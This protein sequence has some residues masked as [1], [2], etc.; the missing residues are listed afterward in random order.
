MF[1]SPG[2]LL[3]V[4]WSLSVTLVSLCLFSCPWCVLNSLCCVLVHYFSFQFYWKTLFSTLASLELKLISLHWLHFPWAFLFHL[5]I[6]AWYLPIL[7]S[8]FL[9]LYKTYSS[10]LFPG[11]TRA[12]CAVVYRSL[13]SDLV[14]VGSVSWFGLSCLILLS[15]P[16]FLHVSQLHGPG[17]R[18]GRL[19]SLPAP[20]WYW[21]VYQLDFWERGWSG[22]I[23]TSSHC[24]DF[25]L[26]LFNH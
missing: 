21:G 20:W 5:P 17:H 25:L 15:L 6:L 14:S 8:Q 19:K 9:I 4:G 7:I 24:Q 1:L 22:K 3:E 16:P 13:Y 26:L 10:Y 18:H 23:Q 12:Y 2:T 11:P